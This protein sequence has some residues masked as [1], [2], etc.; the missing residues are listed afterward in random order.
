VQDIANHQM[1]SLRPHIV[2]SAPRFELSVFAERHR[3]PAALTRFWLARAHAALAAEKYEYAPTS[4]SGGARAFAALAPRTRVVLAVVRGLAD[5]IFEPPEHYPETLFLD[6]AR[7]VQL[8]KDC[9]D[10]SAL[11]AL[12]LLFRQ[13]AA[14]PAPAPASADDT[15]AAAHA[16]RVKAELRELWPPGLGRVFVPACAAAPPPD[17]LQALVLQVAARA[18]EARRGRA[19]LPGTPAPAPAQTLALAQSWAARHLRLGSPLAGC[20]R[21]KL[22]RAVVDAVARAVVGGSGT[23]D[24][25]R[26]TREGARDGLDALAPEVRHVAE[27]MARLAGLHLG[28]YRA[29]YEGEGFVEGL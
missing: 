18:A 12:L 1:Q 7:L 11:Y 13:L 2:H 8:A 20:L 26:L 24:A 16:L 3:A 19:P 6:H 28:V 9:A 4:A 5:L 21:T 17:G 10:L 23:V 25:E 15:H 22:K 29:M 27:R 14:P